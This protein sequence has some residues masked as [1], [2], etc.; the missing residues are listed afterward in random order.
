MRALPSIAMLALGLAVGCN[1]DPGE[2]DEQVG[3]RDNTDPGGSS[4][5]RGTIVFSEVLWSGTVDADGVRDQ[6]D[7]FIE[8]RN[9]SNRPVNLS[10]W[11]LEV[12]GTIE[13]THRIPE[14]DALLEVGGHYLIVAKDDRC[15]MN[16]DAVIE[17]LELPDGGPFR[18]TL[19]DPDERLIEP[20][21]DKYQPP[22]AGGWDGVESRSMER[23]QLM[24][25]GRGTDPH[26]W[27]FYTRAEVDVPNN[28]NIQP[29]CQ[30][31]T[32]ASPGLANSPDYSGAYATGSLE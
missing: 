15:I 23:V 32:L 24:F 9:E 11:F 7:V 14:T 18:V 8:L 2:V 21:G 17:A 1:G 30:T 5:E 19:R 26:M 13:T 27:H 16:A 29:G 10:G 4:G 22:Y 25:G 31:F 20:A 28:T 3:Y 6:T 12:H